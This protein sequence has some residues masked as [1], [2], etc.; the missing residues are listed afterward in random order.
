MVGEC[1]GAGALRLPGSPAL[2]ASCW[3]LV[4]YQLKRGV[5]STRPRRKIRLAVTR[6]VLI[7]SG[8]K[9]PAFEETP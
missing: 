2:V 1:T 6:L 9:L 3:L 8:G 5:N 4:A 7:Y